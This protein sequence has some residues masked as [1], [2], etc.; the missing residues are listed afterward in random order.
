MASANGNILSLIHLQLYVAL[1]NYEN[2]I[3]QK[4]FGTHAKAYACILYPRQ[5][6]KHGNLNWTERSEPNEVQLYKKEDLHEPR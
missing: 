3:K 1:K 4:T 2:Q 5:E 6:N